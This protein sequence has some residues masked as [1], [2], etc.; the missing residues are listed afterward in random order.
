MNHT[1]RL[2]ENVMA[3]LMV[4]IGFRDQDWNE[5]AARKIAPE[6]RQNPFAVCPRYDADSLAARMVRSCGP[7]GA[8]AKP[9][10]LRKT[11][12]LSGSNLTVMGNLLDTRM[13]RG[14][15]VSIP[16]RRMGS[17]RTRPSHATQIKHD[18]ALRSNF[19]VPR[20][21]NSAGR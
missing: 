13:I 19:F 16:V 18:I 15:F 17:T 14:M 7:F 1:G 8:V 3:T 5:V 9:P 20:L 2:S 21:V 10:G 6:S 11:E 4:G 12:S